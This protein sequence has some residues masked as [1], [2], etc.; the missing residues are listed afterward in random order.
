MARIRHTAFAA[1]VTA[2]LVCVALLPVP[3]AA[4]TLLLLPLPLLRLGGVWG[5][6]PALVVALA[7]SGAMIPLLGPEAPLAYLTLVAIP[8]VTGIRMLRAGVALEWVVATTALVS[9]TA[10]AWLACL[11]HGSIAALSS[12]LSGALQASFSRWVAIQRSLGASEDFLRELETLRGGLIDSVLAVAPALLVTSWAAIWFASFW[13]ASRR[14]T[15]PQ[16]LDLSRWE[17]SP[18]LIW[19]LIASGFALFVPIPAVATVARNVFVIML[20]FYFCQ[21]LAI[22]HYYLIRLRLP[23]PLRIASYLLIAVEQ[24]VAAAVLALGVFDLWG[25]F[26]RLRPVGGEIDAGVE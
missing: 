25:D 24:I 23:R 14:C 12:A 11:A 18:W 17:I 26:R 9:A 1:C 13:W 7:S 3:L 5:A 4:G 20:A 10:T 19:V 15:W 22:V 2:L 21:G 8:V 6:G 16:M